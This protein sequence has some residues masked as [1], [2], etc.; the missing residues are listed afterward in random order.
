M[1]VMQSTS[2]IRGHLSYFNNPVAKFPLTYRY[3]LVNVDS[4]LFSVG[5]RWGRV[6]DVT[7]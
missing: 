5:G 2:A 6:E 1:F 4:V 7:R 3:E